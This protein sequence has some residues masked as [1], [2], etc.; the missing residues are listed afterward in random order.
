MM[1]VLL[2]GSNADAL[3]YVVQDG[4][5][6]YYP[7]EN[8]QIVIELK[9][10]IPGMLAFLDAMGVVVDTPVHVILDED[11][12]I[13]QAKVSMIPHREVRIPLRAPGVL[14]EGY[15][16]PDPWAY[17]LFKGLCIQGIYSL[18]SGLPGAAY[19]VVGEVISPNTILPPWIEDG[20]SYLLYTL[21]EPDTLQDPYE[22]A[23]ASGFIEPMGGWL[24]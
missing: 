22:A 16:Y 7:K 20:I 4:I 21:Y 13:P 6:L 11:M 19:K 8:E 12:D 14:E 5:Y 9:D 2:W 23:I 17:F 24:F 18:R 15:L 1:V 3:V 10:K